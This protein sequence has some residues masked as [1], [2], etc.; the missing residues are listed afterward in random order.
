MF[1]LHFHST[2]SD[3]KSTIPELSA[4]IRE[5]NLRYC[6]LTDHNTVD[7]IR[8]LENCLD[9]TMTQ[10]IYGTELTAKYGDDEVH[11]LAYDFNIDLVEKILKERNDL[12]RNQKRE[13]MDLAIQLSRQEGLEVTEALQPNDKQPVTLTT[14]LDICAKRS[15][16][17]LFLRHHNQELSPE[18]LYYKYQAPGKACAVVRSGVTVEWLVNK[19]SGVAR[20][21]IIAHPFVS[22]S[23]VTKPLN[24]QRILEILRMGVTGVEVYHDHTSP[25]QV[26]ML[27]RLVSEKN[28]H[29]SGGSDFH[30]KENSTPLGYFGPDRRVP[31]FR[32]TNYHGEANS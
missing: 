22:V 8:E 18:E 32:L 5:K 25:V 4:M 14:A 29:Y 9:G 24:E 10:V 28:I 3:G 21:I 27:K 23:V 16:Q 11:L 20:D 15:N 26:E 13:E 19:L 7:G 30:G 2:Y 17:E 6:A 12:V 1:D 31:D